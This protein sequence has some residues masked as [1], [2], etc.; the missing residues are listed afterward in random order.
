MTGDETRNKNVQIP[1][2]NGPGGAEEAGA[3]QGELGRPRDVP[4]GT[5]LDQALGDHVTG[6]HQDARR[7]RRRLDAV[8]GQERVEGSQESGGLKKYRLGGEM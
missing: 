6:R 5:T 8:V 7:N 1:V 2:P 3:D 4:A